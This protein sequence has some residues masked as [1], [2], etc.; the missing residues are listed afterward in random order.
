[1]IAKDLCPQTYKADDD[2]AARE[3]WENIENGPSVNVSCARGP[4]P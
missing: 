3:A 1:V 2:T 4:R